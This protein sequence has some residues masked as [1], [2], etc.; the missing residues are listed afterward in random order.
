MFKDR[1]DLVG[2]RDTDR[3]ANLFPMTAFP[4]PIGMIWKRFA[5]TAEGG[6]M[7]AD[8]AF[9]QVLSD[10]GTPYSDTNRS[11]NRFSR[12]ESL[13]LTGGTTYSDESN[14]ID[15]LGTY[16]GIATFCS[17]TT[18]AAISV[19]LNSSSSAEF[20]LGSGNITF[21]NGDLPVSSLAFDNSSSGAGTAN[22][23]VI[24]TIETVS[25]D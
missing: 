14:Q 1:L 10:D 11:L 18:D 19:R 7:T 16:G 24:L 23:D 15:V 9:I 4:M 20:S 13:T 21:D 12:T 25:N 2:L 3:I 5:S 17:I 8:T 6:M 22:V